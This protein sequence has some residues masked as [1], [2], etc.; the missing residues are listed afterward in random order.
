MTAL[1]LIVAAIAAMGVVARS[2]R[3][4][5][6]AR[7]AAKTHHR[8]LDTL[9]TLTRQAGDHPVRSREAED[10]HTHVRLVRTTSVRSGLGATRIGPQ[11]G[12][13]L[14]ASPFRAPPARYAPDDPE[15]AALPAEEERVRIVRSPSVPPVA[16]PGPPA[17]VAAAP[18]L[19]GPVI[20]TPAE[21]ET[22]VASG[23]PMLRFD[24]EVAPVEPPSIPL[25]GVAHL[26][27]EALAALTT[28]A[29]RR[30]Q[31]GAS[32][33][34]GRRRHRHGRRRARWAPS[35]RG[36]LPRWAL[37]SAAASVVVAAVAVGA[38]VASNGRVSPP[39]PRTPLVARTKS[40]VTTPATTAA[41]TTTL[42]SADL[43]SSTPQDA[44]YRLTSPATITL[45][46]SNG[47]SWIELRQGDQVGAV[48][49]QGRLTQGQ[50]KTIAA[51]AWVRLG[52]PTAVTIAINRQLIAPPLTPGQ[53]FNLQFR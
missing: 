49:Y 45:T 35:S 2:A 38:A 16:P 7:R 30:R 5:G 9:D 19:S 22:A 25:P 36:A 3:R 27:P 21:P 10:A 32:P 14:G 50:V 28:S 42:P 8:V 29:H 23:V 20:P 53:P 1:W 43:V 44:V 40:P 47:V 51:P 41:P 4:G 6:P 52:N 18:P 13:S 46:A 24:E 31:E 39:L 15:T 17:P 48:L 34:P 12:R 26:A 11:P 37:V 33:A